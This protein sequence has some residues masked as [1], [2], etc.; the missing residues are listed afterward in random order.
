MVGGMRDGALLLCGVHGVGKTALASALCH[1]A[2]S[3]PSYAFIRKVDCKLLHG[4]SL[5]T[6]N[7]QTITGRKLLVFTTAPVGVKF[8]RV[9]L[10]YRPCPLH[11]PNLIPI[12]PYLGITSRKNLEESLMFTPFSP[13][14]GESLN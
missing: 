7:R 4:I 3:A 11:P 14:R 13:C 2:M 8:D 6:L 10:G 12:S 9:Y 1:E 5:F